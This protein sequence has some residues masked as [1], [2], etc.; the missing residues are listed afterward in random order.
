MQTNDFI[1]ISYTG[2][3]KEGN[4]E[5][6][7]GD[8]V[9]VIVGAKYVID[10]MDEGLQ[11]M[12]IGDKKTIEIPPEKAF[13]ARRQDLVKIVPE[14]EFK[15]N[16][17]KPYPGMFITAENNIKGRVLSVSSGRV[18]VDFNH[19]L[20]GKVLVY[21]VEINSKIDSPEEKIR[22]IFEFYTKTPSEKL[23][24]ELKEKEV[25]IFIA[26]ILH[27]VVKKRIADDIMNF[28]GLEKVKF[29]E[30]FEKSK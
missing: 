14:S 13:G 12:N 29:A 24:L 28:I 26:P 9:P 7:R 21:D 30:V 6:D 4:Q 22:A 1:R 8:K 10:G 23:G 2:R 15:K 19:P 25:E 27:P 5:F 17:T 18:K 20:A 16:N 11:A 3:I